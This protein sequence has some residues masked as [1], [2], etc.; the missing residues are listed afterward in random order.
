[1]AAC[2]PYRL[3]LLVAEYR[4]KALIAAILFKGFLQFSASGFPG[5]R[6]HVYPGFLWP[7]YPQNSGMPSYIRLVQLVYRVDGLNIQ[8]K[9]QSD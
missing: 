1:M 3:G 2:R 4:H 6:N 7:A 8:R 9:L 5:K